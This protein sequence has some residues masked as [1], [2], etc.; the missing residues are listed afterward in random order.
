MTYAQWGQ[1]LT[2]TGRFTSGFPEIVVYNGS[3][4]CGITAQTVVDSSPPFSAMTVKGGLIDIVT[5]GD[6]RIRKFLFSNPKGFVHSFT[7]IDFNK[8]IRPTKKGFWK[9]QKK[10]TKKS[11]GIIKILATNH[12]EVNLF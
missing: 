2:F 8:Y 12:V 6:I 10:R 11:V 5:R 4:F 3:N 1:P 7:D 9:V